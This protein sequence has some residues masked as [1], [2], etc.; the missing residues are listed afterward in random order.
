MF[1]LILLHIFLCCFYIKIIVLKQLKLNHL[2]YNIIRQ[3]FY[4]L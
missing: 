2:Y 4:Y 3:L 1:C